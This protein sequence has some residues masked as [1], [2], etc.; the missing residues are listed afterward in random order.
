LIL[1]G[2]SAGS[3]LSGPAV[4]HTG[5]KI[6]HLTKHLDPLYL[7][8]NQKAA[9]ANQLDGLDST[10]FLRSNGKAAD[11][12]LLDGISSAGFLTA[13]GKAVDSNLLDNLDSTAFLQGAT[14]HTRFFS[15]AGTS[16]FP[17][18]DTITYD[19]LDGLRYPTTG[20]PASFRCNVVIP[21]GATVTRV[22]FSVRDSSGAASVDFT[23][24][25]RTNMVST[26]GTQTEMAD[27]GTTTVGGTPGDIQLSDT[28]I[29]SPVIDNNQ[30]SYYLL[31]GVTSASSVAGC[32]GA[33]VTYTISGSNGGG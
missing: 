28:T 15:C 25:W 13:G 20:T 27:A 23:E 6:F 18:D 30:F 2:I 33:N 8:E 11:A 7:N 24:M 12:D 22:D 1:A 17:D 4:A 26:I 14:T 5:K 32:Y 16:F 19:S 9:D 10:A 29:A 3:L 21:N 31:C